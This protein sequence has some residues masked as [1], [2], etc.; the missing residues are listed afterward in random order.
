MQRSGAN[1][2]L[3]SKFGFFFLSS[4][5][6]IYSLRGIERIILTKC[7][8]G[9][10]PATGLCRA[11]KAASVSGLVSEGEGTRVKSRGVLWGALDVFW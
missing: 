6:G 10:A 2:P 1:D 11:E 8:P 4:D 5:S 9:D 7:K 3:T